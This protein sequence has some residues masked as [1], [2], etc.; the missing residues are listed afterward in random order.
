MRLA[1]DYQRTEVYEKLQKSV[2]DNNIE[3]QKK[4]AELIEVKDKPES[5]EKANELVEVLKNVNNPEAKFVIKHA[6]QLPKKS[7]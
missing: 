4:V 6:D 5:F 3:L 2:Y 1:T 7:Q